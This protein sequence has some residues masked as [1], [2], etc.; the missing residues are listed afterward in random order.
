[1]PREDNGRPLSLRDIADE[2]GVSVSTVSRVLSNSTTKARISDDTRQRV[3]AICEERKFHPNIHYRRLHEGLSRVI[4]F[5]IPTPSPQL[6]F[7]DENVGNF[8]SALEPCLAHHGFHIMIQS[9]TPDFVAGRRHLEIFRSQ[10]VD[11]AI[12]WDVFR[13]NDYLKEMIQEKHPLL[14][15]AFPSDALQDQIVPDNYQGA[16]DLTQHLVDLGHRHI[17][18]VSGGYSRIEKEREAGYLSVMD[19]AD[20]EPLIFHGKYSYQSGYNCAEKIMT[21]N[22][23]VTAIMAAN[24][25][26][27]AG[28][29]RRL[30]ELGYQVP[31]DISVAGFDGTS[32]SAIAEPDIT[33][34]HL[35][36][37]KIGRLAADR[38][39]NAVVDSDNYTPRIT[40]VAMPLIVRGST[41]APRQS[42]STSRKQN[43]ARK[44]V[45]K[46]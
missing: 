7:F 3:L 32:H 18:Q 12:L 30:K 21:Q 46:S 22:P 31:R 23:N 2:A 44:T 5:I 1:M 13:D 35:R 45:A 17:A 14:K 28:C 4:A 10:A 11:A 41:A 43:A 19:A 33:T 39:V 29:L 15:V 27:A 34:A 24:D 20:L 6:L 25:I 26:A 16:R 37:D 42:N 8:L 38:I 9:A 36:L 40:R